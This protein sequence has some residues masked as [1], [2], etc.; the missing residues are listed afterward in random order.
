MSA[1]GPA[2][3][4]VASRDLTACCNAARS[5]AASTS[6]QESDLAAACLQAVAEN[7]AALARIK[8]A[9]SHSQQPAPQQAAGT[10]PAPRLPIEQLV[11]AFVRAIMETTQQVSR[12][13]A[14]RQCAARS[15][16]VTCTKAVPG[17][18][19]LLKSVVC[20]IS[21]ILRHGR[22]APSCQLILL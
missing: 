14:Q 4:H 2:T 17:C 7:P 20:L 10:Q 3:H 6:Q 1:G 21:H 15:W 11:A 12:A 16:H 8:A 13:A 9:A 18:A 5:S 19:L 22:A